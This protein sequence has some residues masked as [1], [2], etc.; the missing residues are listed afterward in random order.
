MLISVEAASVLVPQKNRECFRQC[1]HFPLVMG[2]GSLVATGTSRI[3]L[4]LYCLQH[5][6]CWSC[7][8]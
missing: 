7:C 4:L 2:R 1:H 5:I 8:L 6:L 3:C